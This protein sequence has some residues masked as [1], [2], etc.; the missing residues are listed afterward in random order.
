MM[1][2]EQA[3][4]IIKNKCSLKDVELTEEDSEYIIL[5]QMDNV[6]FNYRTGV[7]KFVFLFPDTDFVIKLPFNGEHYGDE[8]C[9]FCNGWDCSWDY[10][11]TEE[12]LYKLAEAA[13]VE[14][15]FAKTVAI[16]EI[17]NFTIYSQER[18]V[19]WGDIHDDEDYD[20]EKIKSTKEK[21]YSHN[22]RYYCFHEYW[23][24]DCLDYYGDVIFE[25]FMN[26]IEDNGIDDL[27]S[28]NLGYING[29]P[30][31]VDYAGFES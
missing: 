13:G 21:C 25:K 15:C 5:P 12:E 1:T 8:F 20:E 19:I 3:F 31:V 16:G 6:N 14:E 27:H 7:S 9:E 10:C 18:A 30:V 2:S 22:R 24:S 17:D 4:E 11:K 28:N 29:R 23:L 26:F